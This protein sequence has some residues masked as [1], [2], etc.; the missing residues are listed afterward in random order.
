MLDVV[1]KSKRR[2][3]KK[4]NEPGRQ[5][6]EGKIAGGKCRKRAKLFSDLSQVPVESPG[7]SSA[8]SSAPASAT[9]RRG[10][11][12]GIGYITGFTG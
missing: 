5:T 1:W 3:K 4:L 7:F 11:I 9:S 2:R 6:F 12:N 10:G 8:E